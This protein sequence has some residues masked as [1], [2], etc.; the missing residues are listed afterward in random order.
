MVNI[1][2]I[3]NKQVVLL[4]RPAGFPV[5]GKHLGVQTTQVNAV[6]EDNDILLRNLYVSA[7]PYLRGRMDNVKSLY[8]TSFELGKPFSSGGVSE[9]IQSRNPNFPVGA[10]VTGETNWE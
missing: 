8:T 7:D 9:V 3:N 1:N 10:I 5:A 6:L 4:D 2:N